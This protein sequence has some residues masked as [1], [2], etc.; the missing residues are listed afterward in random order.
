MKR[1]SYKMVI[2]S[3]LVFLLL[4]VTVPLTY[5]APPSPPQ[6]PITL[7]FSGTVF[8]KC[9]GEDVDITGEVHIFLSLLT[10]NH[11]STH[12][13]L[14]SYDAIG[15]TTAAAYGVTIESEW[16]SQSPNPGENVSFSMDVPLTVYGGQAAFQKLIRCRLPHDNPLRIDLFFSADG[17]LTGWSTTLNGTICSKDPCIPPQ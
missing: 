12:V 10:R 15:A 7:P 4:G 9:T 14:K 8:N 17:F 1:R 2:T 6:S 5:G 13:F 11:I 16:S 3:G